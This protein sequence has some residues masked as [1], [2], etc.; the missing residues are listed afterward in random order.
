MLAEHEEVFANWL[1]VDETGV[2]PPVCL[3]S[4]ATALHG[5]VV[6]GARV[7]SALVL[8]V[9]GGGRRML[10]VGRADDAVTGAGGEF[11]VVA[12]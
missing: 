11:G 6:V 1:G 4:V 3:E 9:A 12:E 7:A 2:E 8:D 5:G 10:V